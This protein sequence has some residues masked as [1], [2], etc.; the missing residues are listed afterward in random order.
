M[1]TGLGGAAAG[2]AIAFF[3]RKFSREDETESD[4]VGQQ[5]MAKAGYDP[6]EASR[7]WERMGQASSGR[8][9]PEF[10]STHP[11]D[12]TR[13]NNLTSWLPEAMETY[14]K[15]PNKYGIGKPIN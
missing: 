4:K 11:S 7:V 3:D 1:L 2:F 6:R 12:A 5:Y 15:A 10:L 9:P 14:L 13:K 8:A